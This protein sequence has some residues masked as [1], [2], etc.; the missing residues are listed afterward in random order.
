MERGRLKGMGSTLVRTKTSASNIHKAQLNKVKRQPDWKVKA[1][2]LRLE[3]PANELP[4]SS[5]SAYSG[6]RPL[7]RD[8]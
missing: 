3:K 8:H 6:F 1:N 7:V 4:I 5:L 2:T